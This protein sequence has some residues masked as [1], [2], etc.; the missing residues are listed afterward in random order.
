MALVALTR[1]VVAVEL[2]VVAVVVRRLVAFPGHLVLAPDEAR[3]A[4]FTPDPAQGADLGE[5]PLERGMPGLECGPAEL[6]LH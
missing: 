2:H 5:W 4:R 6:L 1:V 3:Q